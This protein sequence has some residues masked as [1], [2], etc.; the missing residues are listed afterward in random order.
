M[1]TKEQLLFECFRTGLTLIM[2]GLEEA[3][4][5][6]G[7]ARVRLDHVIRRYAA[8]ITSD[9]GWCMVQAENQDLSAAMSRQIKAFKSRI[10]Q[11][12]RQ[13]LEAGARDGSLRECDAKIT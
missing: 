13:M 10:D 11:G 3:G 9:F 2:D 6:P 4:Q 12:I 8:A 7:P 1:K 5:M